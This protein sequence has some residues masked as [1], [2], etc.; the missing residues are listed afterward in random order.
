MEERST[1]ERGFTA[2]LWHA[3]DE[4]YASILEHPFLRGLTDGTLS[5]ESFLFYVLQRTCNACGTVF[6]LPLR[7]GYLCRLPGPDS[8][9]H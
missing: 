2:E 6:R 1:R 7:V 8:K 4:I 9:S 5:E 3:I